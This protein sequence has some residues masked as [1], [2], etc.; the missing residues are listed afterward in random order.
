ML[1]MPLANEIYVHF[2]KYY[3]QHYYVVLYVRVGRVLLRI[4][5]Y[6]LK[7]FFEQKC[8]LLFIAQQVTTSNY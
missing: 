1:L 2:G 4:Y 3:M 6:I 8:N 7:P 5:I